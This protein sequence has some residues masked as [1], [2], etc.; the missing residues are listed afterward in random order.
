M[1]KLYNKYNTYTAKVQELLYSSDNW[2]CASIISAKY[3][4]YHLSM[5]IIYL[6]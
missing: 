2:D 1:Y 6:R 5:Y 4:V 3:D